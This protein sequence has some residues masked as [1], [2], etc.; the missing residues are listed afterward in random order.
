M[1]LLVKYQMRF[2]SI[3]LDQSIYFNVEGEA[4]NHI[5]LILKNIH[6]T[7]GKGEKSLNFFLC[8]YYIKI[9]QNPNIG[10][11][12]GMDAQLTAR[13]RLYYKW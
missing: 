5:T 13:P 10:Y 12:R 11:N 7:E 1:L 9:D 3:F 6:N 8:I 2:D 4:E